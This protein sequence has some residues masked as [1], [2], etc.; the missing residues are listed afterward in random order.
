MVFAHAPISIEALYIVGAI[1]LV[2]L[3]GLIY[4]A[5]KVMAF[6]LRCVRDVEGESTEDE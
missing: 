2:V 1:G 4:F 3:A 5:A 6:I